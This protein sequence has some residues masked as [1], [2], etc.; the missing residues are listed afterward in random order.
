MSA[1]DPPLCGAPRSPTRSPATTLPAGA[2]DCHLHIFDSNHPMVRGRK[3]TPPAASLSSYIEL[4]KTLGLERAVVVQPSV[5]GTD[6]S[7]TLNAVRAGGDSFRAVVVVEPDAPLQTLCTM[8]EKGA[9]GVRINPLFDSNARTNSVLLFASRLAE[10]NWHVQYLLDVSSIGD[11]VALAGRLPVPVVFDHFGHLPVDKGVHNPGFQS[12]LRLVGDGRAWVKLSGAYRITGNA[13]TP[14]ADVLPFVK[15][16]INA[17]PERLLWG[18]DW[19]HPH[20]PVSMP[21][22]T[23]LLDMMLQWLPD[24][25]LRQQIFV[26]NPAKLYGFTHDD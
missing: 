14:Y 22:D 7:V 1:V 21:D 24:S 3:Y 23:N 5:Y 8:R 19:P 15:A 6:N 17:N 9:R 4:Q 13:H 10:L 16:L 2:C 11:L 25:T 12:L 20:I 26:D 18:S